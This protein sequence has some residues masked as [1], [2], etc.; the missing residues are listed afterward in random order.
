MIVDDLVAFSPVVREFAGRG[1]HIVRAPFPVCPLGTK[2]SRDDF[3]I[4]LNKFD[5]GVPESLVPYTTVDDVQGFDGSMAA[6]P[7]PRVILVGDRAE[8]GVVCVQSHHTKDGTWLYEMYAPL[9]DRSFRTAVHPLTTKM[10]VKPGDPRPLI[11]MGGHPEAKHWF[12]SEG[13][14][15]ATREELEEAYLSMHEN[16]P[17]EV[18][19]PLKEKMKSMTT[20]NLRRI[21]KLF[22]YAQVHMIR[23]V[24]ATF[25]LMNCRNIVQEAVEHSP[26]LQKSRARAGKLPLYRYHVLK[27]RGLTNRSHGNGKG[28]AQAIHWVRG[29][30]KR[31]TEEKPLFG[32]FTGTYWWQHHLAGQADR[33]VE[34]SYE[35][36]AS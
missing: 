33:V 5:D 19:D 13:M 26:A 27:V 3:K 31:Y 18:K 11:T 12:D 25:A 28:E 34:K 23:T 17:E 14:E 21:V 1:A 20:E 32:K 30:F 29:H 9:I 8:D 24:L 36:V 10:M 7:Y 15:A 22:I 35:V 2:D 6:A 4:I 16:E